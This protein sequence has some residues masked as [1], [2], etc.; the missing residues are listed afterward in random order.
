MAIPEFTEFGLLPEGIHP[1]TQDEAADFLCTNDHRANIWQGLQ[2]FMEWISHL[3]P[4]SGVLVDG[5]FV[6]DKPLPS[7]VD[8]II[9][10]SNCSEVEY[11]QWS[12][13]WSQGLGYAKENFRVDFYPV[14]TGHGHDFS[15]FFQY[16]RI[17]D[18]LQRGVPPTT[19]KGILKVQQ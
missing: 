1:C 4:P 19:R 10:I 13:F 2:G 3:P 17:D 15:T 5:S 16:V 12:Q 7:D 8:V 9:D 11:R 14:V 18:A 6:T